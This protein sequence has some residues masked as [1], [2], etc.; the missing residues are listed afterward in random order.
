[1]HVRLPLSGA[2]TI[3][4]RLNVIVALLTMLPKRIVRSASES[5]LD[6]SIVRLLPASTVTAP[7]KV[8]LPVSDKPPEPLMVT[9]P[10]PL[11][12]PL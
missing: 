6:R 3:G 5:Q 7:V 9:P 8:L 11:I 2:P 12:T 10:A 4:T 1:M